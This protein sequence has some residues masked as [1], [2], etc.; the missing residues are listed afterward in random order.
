MIR[1]LAR[2]VAKC[3]MQNKASLHRICSHNGNRGYGSKKTLHNNYMCGGSR[4]Y[5]AAHWRDFV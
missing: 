4:S 5:F 1:G 3:K 2:A